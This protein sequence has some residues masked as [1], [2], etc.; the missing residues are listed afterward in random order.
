MPVNIYLIAFSDKLFKIHSDE[1]LKRET[2]HLF[3]AE[4]NQ[5]WNCAR[6]KSLT[7]DQWFVSVFSDKQLSVGL[8]R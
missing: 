1:G 7:G 8:L 3:I 2:K 5:L 6:F 4:P